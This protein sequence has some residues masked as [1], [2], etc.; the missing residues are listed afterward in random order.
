MKPI[1]SSR[2]V[3]RTVP[4]SRLLKLV[5]A[6][7]L[8]VAAAPV[9]VAQILAPAA[10]A[11]GNA[12]VES[13]RDADIRDSRQVRAQLSPKRYTT[14]AAEIG[15][16]INSLPVPEG[17]T[18]EAGQVLI[19]FD[20][21]VQEAQLNRAE[22]TLRAAESTWRSNRRLEELNSVGKLELDVSRAEVDKNNA[23]VAGM[24]AM[25]SKCRVTA[26]FAGRVAEQK[27]REQQFVQ[28]GQAMID[29]LDDSVLEIE[30]IVPSRWLVW[31]REGYAFRIRI[32]ETGKSYPASVQRIGA[33]VDPVSQ[34]IKIV[35]A[36]NG[37][38]PELLSGMSGRAGFDDA[39]DRAIRKTQ[40]SGMVKP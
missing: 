28:P 39:Y 20:C 15:A 29:I 16:K 8:T 25:L 24:A 40:P 35:A 7:L 10:S 12:P 4:L 37:R 18:F 9:A 6:L 21:T 5:G 38:F 19:A 27:V 26:P 14:L 17:G 2:H 11:Q 31:L 13:R 33:R 23:E 36:I 1:E 32:D 22:A 30:F 3:S 34:S